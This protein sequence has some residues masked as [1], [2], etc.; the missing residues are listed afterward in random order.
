MMWTQQ[1]RLR[2]EGTWRLWLCS[3]SLSAV[4]PDLLFYCP[5]V[6]QNY[7]FLSITLEK[8]LFSL[9]FLLFL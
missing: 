4:F 7:C 1:S 8:V 3:W 5:H 2:R 9:L 6:A